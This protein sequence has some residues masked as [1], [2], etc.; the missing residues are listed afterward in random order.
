MK[1]DLRSRA[2]R[3]AKAVMLAADASFTTSA[4]ALS[5]LVKPFTALSLKK[6]VTLLMQK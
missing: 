3:A 5:D 6:Q 4:Q 2:R 1:R